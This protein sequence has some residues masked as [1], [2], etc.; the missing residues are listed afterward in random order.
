MLGAAAVL[1]LRQ[2]AELLPIKDS[3]AREWLRSEG[4]V[5]D[6]R[7]REIVIWGDVVAALGPDDTPPPP[8]K[9]GKPLPRARL[10]PIGP[11]R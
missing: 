2:A 1:P 11:R 3:S 4:L 10:E 5:R 6:L 8:R 9:R 7:G